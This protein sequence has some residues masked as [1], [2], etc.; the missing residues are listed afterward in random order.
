MNLK[1]P[2]IYEMEDTTFEYLLK[3]DE[4]RTIPKSNIHA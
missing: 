2:I 3:R 1:L 4:S